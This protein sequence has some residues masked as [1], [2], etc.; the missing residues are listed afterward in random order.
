MKRILALLCAVSVAT[1]AIA[2]DLDRDLRRRVKALVVAVEE[3]PTT[4]DT[5]VERM[6]VL[7]EWANAASLEGAFVPKNLTL[8]G[9]YVP[10]PR[11]G[12]EISPRYVAEID[13]WVRHLASL[14]DDPDAFGTHPRVEPA[15]VEATSWQTMSV[16]W[17]V[18]S[19]GV[20][21][22]GGILASRHIMGG[23]APIQRD[24]P[25]AD[26]YV[27]VT[28][29]NPA[30]RFANDQAS[31][32]GPYGGFRAAQQ[33]PVF[34]LVGGSLREGD[35]LTIT[36]GDRSGG[37]RGFGI[38]SFTNTA[39]ALPLL[40]D[41]GDGSFYELPLATY[42][43]IGTKAAG[44]H[45]F[46]PSI[47]A[48]GESFHISLRT[49]DG[50]YN[51]A[52]GTIPAYEMFRNGEKVGDIPAGEAIREIPI[53]LDEEGVYRFSFRSADGTIA[54][55]ANP[56]WVQSAP[57]HR[58]YW[59]ETHGHCGF[60]EGQ[61]TP[62]GYF[63]FALQDARLDFVTLS[64]H[65]IWLTDGKWRTLNEV[66]REYHEEGRLAVFPGYE[67]SAPRERGG[68]HNVFFRGP[69]FERVPVQ[70]AWDLTKLY[71]GLRAKHDTDDVLIIP[72]AHQAGDW[73][74]SDLDME[75]LIEVMSSH[76]TFEWFGQR[77]LDNGYRVGFVGA[78]DDHIGHPGY[79]P[80]H[81]ANGRRRSNIFQFG[82]LAAAWAA[83]HSTDDIFDALKARHA[84]G[85]TGAQRIILDATLN[86]GRM[87]RELP[88]AQ[89]RTIEGRAI[90]TGPIRKI[91][92]IKNGEVLSSWDLER[93]A[94]EQTEQEVVVGFHSES[95]V[96]FRDNPRGHITWR[97][98][99]TVEN[100]TLLEARHLGTPS[101]SADRLTRAGN[102]VTFDVATRGARRSVALEIA[103]TSPGTRLHF[104]L[105]ET[106]EMGTAPAQRR[107]PD[108]FAARSFS[109]AL[110]HGDDVQ[111]E[112]LR[113]G[114][115]RDRVVIE[116]AGLPDD[117]A[118]SFTDSG[119]PDD[120]YYLRVEQLDGHLAWSS[121]WWV[122][123]ETP[124]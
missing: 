115:Y 23:Y 25:G 10:H 26:N 45:G 30:I 6:A 16:E 38:G 63:D 86:D 5:A 35:T 81:P 51:R 13:T 42:E 108:T 106:R 44:V 17:T 82:G 59:G 14:D 71:R 2:Y 4:A 110:P 33:F 123:G 76:G 52:T 46:A 50:H 109:L 24:D 112:E 92:L 87:G 54:G 20:A 34:R 11:P 68:H 74:L 107:T 67:W 84:Y 40:V 69:G 18:G 96:A 28:S 22:G 65:D 60:A 66:A 32:T 9:V 55:D 104:E 1:P 105:D 119:N 47:V 19:L 49:E 31:V 7:L 114:I 12:T 118:F 113:T 77:Y 93:E 85:T 37:S 103:D 90:G 3:T 97:G 111:E 41:P 88:M 43:V 39:I 89:R 15:V 57:A 62:R 98:T 64:E 124:R 102:T 101:T 116:R 72:H 53:R 117:V 80:G 48:T 99:I 95:W 79:A 122:G 120:A 83:E 70:E 29:S 73:R 75:T 100:G 58:L 121:P 78:S 91:D 61:G 21:E 36:Y 8:A 56:V 27:T 94:D